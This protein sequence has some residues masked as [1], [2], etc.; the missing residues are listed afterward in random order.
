MIGF[1]VGALSVVVVAG[2]A[3][4]AFWMGR[5]GCGPGRHGGCGGRGHGGRGCHAG[6]HGGWR[7]EWRGE[8]GAGEGGRRGS[9][10]HDEAF[11]RAMGEVFK[12]R[13]DVDEDQE[14]YVD[15]ALKDL[16]AALKELSDE[17]KATRAPVGEA[18]RGETVD[19]AALAA[20]FAR[21]D[22][23]LG[24]ARR[25]VV[26]ALKQ[27]HAVLTPEQRARAVEWIASA[28]RP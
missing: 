19:D 17:L 4:R 27:V 1:L 11:A 2:V 13:L 18:F 12:R 3:R 5:H 22:D 23:A 16:R 8:G 9:P 10:L 24:R 21:H 6:W 28:E 20:A 26:S 14:P 7:G 25:Q 15:H